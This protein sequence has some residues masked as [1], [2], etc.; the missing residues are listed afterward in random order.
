MVY[1]FNHFQGLEV[2]HNALRAKP[3]HKSFRE[4]KMLALP[5]TRGI[6]V[7]ITEFMKE[8][9]KT[10]SQTF[11]HILFSVVQ[12]FFSLFWNHFWILMLMTVQCT[13]P[14]V[15]FLMCVTE[16][17]VI[18]GNVSPDTEQRC[19]GGGSPARITA[20]HPEALSV[21]KLS[22]RASHQARTSRQCA[23][24]A[25]G[26]WHVSTKNSILFKDACTY[27]PLRQST[28]EIVLMV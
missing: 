25:R 26:G 27:L 2:S 19:A 12:T 17:S 9:T 22:T 10:T 16:P 20:G 5:G 13:M 28:N 18:R 1:C 23:F 11:A 21:C 7:V 4:L 15:W 3:V 24:L 14:H 6:A 8:S